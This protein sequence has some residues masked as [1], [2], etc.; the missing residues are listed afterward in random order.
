MRPKAPGDTD[1][2]HRAVADGLEVDERRFAIN[3]QDVGSVRRPM[4][5]ALT[6]AHLSDFV[7]PVKN[8]GEKGPIASIQCRSEALVAEYA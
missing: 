1:P 8:V 2:T 6:C 5:G 7:T 3:H 4:Q